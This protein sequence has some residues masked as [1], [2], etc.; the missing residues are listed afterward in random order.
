[1]PSL[2]EPCGLPQMT[3]TI[4]GSLPIV[5]NTGGLH[6]SISHLN[7]ETQTGNGFRFDNY[8]IGGLSWAI[9]QAMD[10]YKLNAKTKTENIERIMIESLERFNH[11]VTAQGYIDIY[12][13]MLHRPLVQ[14]K[15]NRSGVKNV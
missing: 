5:R 3:A 7:I 12:Q 11:T 13:K 6:D 2:F 8:D 9:D 14:E 15:F 10:F 1:M 4:Y